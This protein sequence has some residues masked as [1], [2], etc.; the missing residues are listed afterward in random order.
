VVALDNEGRVRW[1]TTLDGLGLPQDLR[2]DAATRRVF[3]LYLLAPRY[4]QIAIL[5]ADSG[6]ILSRI[7]PTLRRPLRK[8]SDQ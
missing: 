2:Y 8:I 6:E 5:D 4:G 7:E 1:Q 3:V